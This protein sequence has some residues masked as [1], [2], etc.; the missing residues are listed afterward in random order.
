MFVGVLGIMQ[1]SLFGIIVISR[2]YSWM[3]GPLILSLGGTL[4]SITYIRMMKLGGIDSV[5]EATGANNSTWMQRGTSLAQNWG[6]LGL[7]ILNATPCPSAIVCLA[8][9]IASIDSYKIILAIFLSRITTNSVTAYMMRMATE[10][11]TAEEYI[12]ALAEGKPL[13]PMD[14][15]N[16]Q[17]EKQDD[18]KTS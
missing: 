4:S 2:K 14:F 15:M 6:F 9:V 18:K 8:G 16:Q 17:E 5:L 13:I 3:F 10:N 11:M 12:R 1:A 7:F